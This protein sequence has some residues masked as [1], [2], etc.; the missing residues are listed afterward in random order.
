MKRFAFRFQTVLDVRR[1][2]EETLM[3]ELSQ[4]EAVLSEAVTVLENLRNKESSTRETLKEKLQ[5]AISL[6][7]VGLFQVYLQKLAG[8]IEEQKVWVAQ[9]EAWVQEKRDEV[10]EAL[11][12]RK[13]MEKIKEKDHTLYRKEVAR[14]DQNFLDE[15]VTSHYRRDGKAFVQSMGIRKEVK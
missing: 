5:A 11:K 2:R 3:R 7:E 4:R 10:V 15:I 12:A 13:V 14:V 6:L 9:L 1:Q 8:A